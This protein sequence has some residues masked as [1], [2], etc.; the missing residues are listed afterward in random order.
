MESRGE[1][2]QCLD[3]L[4]TV[5]PKIVDSRVICSDCNK[6]IQ[7]Y[8]NLSQESAKSPSPETCYSL[9]FD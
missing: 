5:E 7:I 8:I 6:P 3:C 1:K 9:K 4:T 2:I